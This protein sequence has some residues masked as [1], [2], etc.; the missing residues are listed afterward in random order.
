MLPD[1]TRVYVREA[2][3]TMSL[4]RAGVAGGVGCPAVFAAERQTGG[5]GRLGRA[6]LSPRG[7]LYATLAV[8]P[9][10]GAERLGEYGFLASLAVLEGAEALGA[11][12]LSLK[13]PNDVLC[14][15]GKVGGVLLESV[16]S[17]GEAEF[18][19]IG[20]GV[21]LRGELP[22]GTGAVCLC[23]LGISGDVTAE[24]LLDSVLASFFRW[25]ER[26]M[27]GGFGVVREAWCERGHGVG[28]ELEVDG[29]RLRGFYAGLDERGYLL[30]DVDGE[31]HI[32]SAG[33]IMT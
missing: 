20:W 29:G 18:L 31:R 11:E 23:D 16:V 24:V 33:D 5:Y 15:G 28:D 27:S 4:A 22:A 9:G 1:L 6:W 30:L 32:I 12:G 17:G 3:S 25:R 14:A 26:W 2:V 8:A 10:V 21:N 13:W 7:N 19:L